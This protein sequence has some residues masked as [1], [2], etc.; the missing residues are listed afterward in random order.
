VTALWQDLVT[1]LVSGS[2]LVAGTDLFVGDLLPS[3]DDVTVLFE[4][5]GMGPRE[6]F[7]DNT[8]P[9]VI[10]PRIQV[11]GRAGGTATAAYTNART[12]VRTVYDLLTVVANEQLSGTTYFRGEAIQEPFMLHRDEN[13]RVVFACN[14]DIWRV[15]E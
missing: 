6:T 5:P 15:A 14:F 13:D 7:G 10:R 2:T 1:Y 3:P 11:L 8:K 12:R 9:A 4:Y